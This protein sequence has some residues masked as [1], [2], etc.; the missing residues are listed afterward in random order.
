MKKSIKTDIDDDESDTEDDPEIRINDNIVINIIDYECSGITRSGEKCKVKIEKLTGFCDTFHKILQTYT[1]QQIDQFIQNPKICTQCKNYR[2]VEK[3]Q[4]HC[5]T[6]PPKNPICFGKLRDGSQCSSHA[7]DESKFC[8][9]YHVE[10]RDYTDTQ[11]VTIKRCKKCQNNRAFDEG[12][13]R[14]IHCVIKFG[15]SKKS[16]KQIK[17]EIREQRAACKAVSKTGG[18]CTKLAE[19]ESIYCNYYHNHWNNYTEADIK[20]VNKCLKCEN[21]KPL[22]PKHDKQWC[23]DCVNNNSPIC[24]GINSDG[25]ACKVHSE[26]GKL[27]CNKYHGDM[28]TYTQYQIDNITPCPNCDLYRFV[29][30]GLCTKCITD[31]DKIIYCIGLSE[32]Q[33]VCR[34]TIRDN[35]RT[36][37]YHS[38]MEDYTDFMLKNLKLCKSCPRP[39]YRY[40]EDDVGMC[41]KCVIT[42]DKT[43]CMGLDGTGKRCTYD[44][45]NGTNF[46][47]RNHK[48]LV[49]YTQYMLKNQK[50]CTAGHYR[51]CEPDENTCMHC[52]NYRL[53][54]RKM[55]KDLL[56]ESDKC[57]VCKEHPK[58]NGDYCGLHYGKSIHK[59]NI[60]KHNN[61]KMCANV[62]RK[63]NNMLPKD[64]KFTKCRECLDIDNIK[65]KK[66]RYEKMENIDDLRDFADNNFSNC[67]QCNKMK[68]IWC[69][70]TLCGECSRRCNTCREDNCDNDATRV[71]KNIWNN[72]KSIKQYIRNA[73]EH[74]RN[75]KWNL[76]ID[77]AIHIIT[78]SCNYCGVYKEATND[79]GNKYSLIGIDRYDNK[80]DYSIDN[81]KP[82]C[83]M[84]NFMKY[85]Y[86]HQ[87][88]LS[89]CLNIY[90]YFGSIVPNNTLK[91]RTYSSYKIQAGKIN[92]PF[93]ISIEEFKNILKNDCYYCNGMNG[94]EQIG[95]DRM[96]SNFGYCTKTNKLVAACGICNTMKKDFNIDIFFNH[97]IDILYFN[98]FISKDEYKQKYRTPEKNYDENDLK[99]LVNEI[100]NSLIDSTNIEHDR[101]T[102]KNY[103]DNDMHYIKNIWNS[104]D[105]SA[106]YPEIV[107]C[108]SVILTDMWLFYRNITSSFKRTNHG[109]LKMLIRDKYSQKYLGLA[110]LSFVTTMTMKCTDI[111]NFLETKDDVLKNKI[112]NIMNITTCVPLQPFGYNFCGGKLIAKLMFSKEVYEYVYKRYNKRHI[113]AFLTFSLKG[114]SIQYSDIDELAYIGQTRGFGSY[115]V[116]QSLIPRIKAKLEEFN[117]KITRNNTYNI[118]NFCRF[119]GIQDVTYHGEKKG[120]YVG[121]TGINSKKYIQN[122]TM[123]DEYC[124]NLKT[125]NE[126]SIEWFL[127]H[128]IKR[129]M[130]LSK[131][132]MIKYKSDINYDEYFVSDA[133]YNRSRMKS[134]YTP[135]N[136]TYIKHTKETTNKIL[137]MWICDRKV[138]FNKLAQNISHIENIV[139]DRRFI[140]NLILGNSRD[141]TSDDTRNLIA[142]RQEDLENK[143]EQSLNNNTN[144]VYFDTDTINK[145]HQ[146][147][148]TKLETIGEN[149]S[150]LKIKIK[151]PKCICILIFLSLI[152][153]DKIVY[154]TKKLTLLSKILKSVTGS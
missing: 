62:S 38:D 67:L 7:T 77:Q 113:Y 149:D 76:T 100:E 27:Y 31:R 6:C 152:I 68:D 97:I 8:T 37:E 72:E 51:Y 17:K 130:D 123:S 84:C 132:N 140:Q 106:L 25:D 94:S 96:D 13:K 137:N 15:S 20:R 110:E 70:Y 127:E 98:K 45:A 120:I 55:N 22:L 57:I 124:H 50:L 117:I 56:D 136:D 36:C 138:S 114:E 39:R 133:G 128:A 63:C 64:Y 146:L 79:D 116:K 143:Y 105:V 49:N 86:N 154:H 24:K 52:K 32:K 23:D 148:I 122:V 111:K 2:L 69:F 33:T 29:E 90:M 44:K 47:H 42:Y 73:S 58:T 34:F 78:Q 92:R 125:V 46:C 89:H 14:C 121:Y 147:N 88:F 144:C 95:I 9:A 18:Q 30:A 107:F 83:S 60:A 66:R 59:K 26:N 41:N 5:V 129:F 115:K 28:N 19:P 48:D 10:M 71:I 85:T 16:K 65:D 81:V 101:R 150:R 103:S 139:V 131:R 102:L 53:K 118:S 1:Q 82:S 108:N 142:K 3:N 35:M 109:G 87:Q 21:Y 12:E 135:K 75:K 43:K 126:L 93:R 151:N 141:D 4:D 40:F 104:F 153:P 99:T 54:S 145:E 80:N 134:S 74:R 11:I 61:M 119:V 91:H 112:N